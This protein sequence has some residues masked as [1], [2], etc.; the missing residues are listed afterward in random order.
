MQ[1][2]R[3]YVRIFAFLKNNRIARIMQHSAAFEK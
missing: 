3:T 1:K 2:V